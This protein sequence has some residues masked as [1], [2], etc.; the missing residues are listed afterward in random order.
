MPHIQELPTTAT[1]RRAPGFAW[2][3]DTG[4]DPSKAPLGTSNKKRAR[5]SAAQ[6]QRHLETATARQLKETERRIRELNKDSTRDVQIAIPKGSK[7]GKTSNTKRIL[8]SGKDFSHYLEDEEAE[9]A[10]RKGTVVER[11]VETVPKPAQRASKTPIARRKH[12]ALRESTSASDSPAPG[13]TPMGA[14]SL[15]KEQSLYAHSE[16]DGMEVDRDDNDL[17]AMPTEAEIQALLDAPPLSY[18]QARSAPPPPEAPAQRTF[19]EMCGYWGRVRCMKCGA[20]VC[21]MECKDSHDAERCLRF[22]A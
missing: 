20:R 21:G 6:D 19:C 8:T 17:P 22:Y 1:D 2:V 18:N 15:L 12:Q 5:T 14:P 11:E 7:V 3:A 4:Y 13:S 10:R 16:A 9:I